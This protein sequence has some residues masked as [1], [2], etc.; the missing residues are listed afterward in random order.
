[1]VTL[2]KRPLEAQVGALHSLYR[3]AWA[4]TF[5]ERR[6]LYTFERVVVG[7]LAHALGRDLDAMLV[8][9]RAGQPAFAPDPP[10]RPAEPEAPGPKA[11]LVL[12]RHNYLGR[13]SAP[14]GRIVVGEPSARSE[15]TFLAHGRPGDWHAYLKDAGD[16]AGALVLIHT[17]ALVHYAKL[18]KT[19]T[20]IALVEVE[21]GTMAMIAAEARDDEKLQE[22]MIFPADPIVFGSACTVTT[23]GDGGHRLRGAKLDN[24]L[25]VALVVDF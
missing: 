14:S 4:L 19:L 24:Q 21:G 25:L 8:E 17:D 18:K 7:E 15:N 13:I 20:E 22:A 2:L 1:M 12:K 5:G 9:I 6:L 10:P 3:T 11:P 16:D 23:N